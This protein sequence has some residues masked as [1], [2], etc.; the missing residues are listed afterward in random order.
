MI[1]LIHNGR[2]FAGDTP[3]DLAEMGVPQAEIDAAVAA[4]AERAARDQLRAKIGAT[5]GD[6]A[7]LLGTTADGAQLAVYELGK[8]ATALST[9]Q[10][11]AEMRAA[12]APLA[13]LM[14]DFLGRVERGETN[15]TALLKGEPVVLADIETRSNAV[16]AA[17]VEN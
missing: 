5:A 16:C 11:L 3:A 14:A 9:A 2:R 6:T 10:S 8:L 4:L 7:S 13:A 1:E 15:L 17:M 12:A